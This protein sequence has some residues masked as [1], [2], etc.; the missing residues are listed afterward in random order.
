MDE[1]T[2]EGSAT[3]RLFVFHF[4]DKTE[5]TPMYDLSIDGCMIEAPESLRERACVVVEL[6]D[7]VDGHGKVICLRAGHARVLFD[8]QIHPVIVQYLGFH[9][10]AE[11]IISKAP[12][13]R[14]GRSLPEFQ[15]PN[16]R[17]AFRK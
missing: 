6:L 17:G 2:C 5:L 15:F 9:Q 10:P 7:N 3:D 12:T 11:I 1:R 16:R 8:K 14:F 13:D 4:D